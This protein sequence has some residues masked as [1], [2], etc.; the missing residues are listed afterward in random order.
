MAIA[1]GLDG[2]L[3]YLGTPHPR[4]TIHLLL[5]IG[6]AVLGL[7]SIE[8]S[9]LLPLPLYSCWGGLMPKDLNK[10]V[11]SGVSLLPEVRHDDHRLVFVCGDKAWQPNT[12]PGAILIGVRV[13]VAMLAGIC[14][15]MFG[16][17]RSV[18]AWM[19][20][21]FVVAFARAFS[22]NAEAVVFCVTIEGAAAQA[23]TLALLLLATEGS[24]QKECVRSAC[25]VLLGHAVGVA[26]GA[27][28]I[29]TYVPRSVYKQMARSLPALVFVL[30]LIALPES[31][32]WAVC[33]GRIHEAIKILKRSHHMA[34]DPTVQAKLSSLYQ[35]HKM[36]VGQYKCS[37]QALRE[38]LQPIFRTRRIFVVF[39]LFALCGLAAGCAVSAVF[40]Y[41]PATFNSFE[42][43]QV[44]LGVI[45]FFALLM[46]GLTVSRLSVKFVLVAL[47]CCVSVA[48]LL[49]PLLEE[50]SVGSCGGQLFFTCLGHMCV[51]MTTVWLGVGAI[52]M[53]P[54][55][56][57]GAVLGF[58][59]AMA[60]LG[61]ALAYLNVADGL[62][63]ITHWG[64]YGEVVV[65][66]LV[67]FIGGLLTFMLPKMPKCLP[68]TITHMIFYKVEKK[69]KEYVV[70]P[71]TVT[72]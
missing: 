11:C 12:F 57:R 21:Y 47:M 13:F 55:H 63:F 46:M 40:L 26:A 34:F 52:R 15:D 33:R 65:W 70:Q 36:S 51:V 8:V 58:T 32:R 62:S 6:M 20:L 56:S 35:E 45:E 68:D 7:G 60:T 54:T 25:L 1:A 66:A 39:L 59:F 28:L 61:H 71:C 17:R 29:T 37:G 31:A 42:D 49:V 67:S 18:V 30:F 41:D 2:V 48:L 24:T 38:S 10:R 23:S 69:R 53:T 22:P 14:M 19:G 4:V 3:T 44:A 50:A 9:T 16:R 43:R 72:L 5:T 27:P 64:I